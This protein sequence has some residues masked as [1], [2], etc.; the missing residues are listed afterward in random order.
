[1]DCALLVTHQDMTDSGF[2]IQG[3]VQGED[4]PPR[5]AENSVHS[6]GNEGFKQGLRAVPA[7]WFVGGVHVIAL[8]F[9]RYGLSKFIP[10]CH[11]SFSSETGSPS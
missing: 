6:V 11:Y 5:I 8:Y 7:D 9:I 1:M 10:F 2:G 4:R 3:I